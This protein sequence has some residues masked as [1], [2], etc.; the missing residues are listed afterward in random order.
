MPG[1]QT[2]FEKAMSDGHSSA[3]DQQW[4][5]AAGFYRAALQE[6]P[7][8]HSAL[9]N[10]G[11]ALF[12]Q[13]NF[14]EAL[15]IYQRAAILSPEDPVPPEKMARIYERLGRLNEA[16]RA[17]MQA[18]ELYLKTRDVEKSIEDWIRVTVLQPENLTAYTRLAMIY[19]RLGRKPEAVA[20]YLNAASLFQHAG[21]GTKALQIIQYAQNLLPGSA[22]AQQYLQAL[23][24]GNPLPRPVRPRGGTGPVRMAEVRQL[25]AAADAD[26]APQLDPISEA[27]QRALVELAGL[28]FDQSEDVLSSA[29]AEASGRR[30]INA[31]ARGTGELTLDSRQQTKV[32]LHLGQAI[33][34][35]THGE[36][37]RAGDELIRAVEVGFSHPALHF[38]IGYL[39]AE[40]DAAKA[41]RSLHKAV[42]APDYA[43]AANLLLGK[44]AYQAK[45]YHDAAGYDLQAMRLADLETVPA[46]KRDELYQLYEPA[47]ESQANEKDEGRLKAFCESIASQLIRADWRE[48]LRRARAQLPEQSPEAPPMPLSEMLVESRSAGVIE[49]LTRI[50]SL[51]GRGMLQTAMEE[52]FYTLE[53]APTY[54]PLHTAI[55]DLLLQDGKVTDAV[56][57]YMLVVR[58][59][60]LRGDNT[61]A[62]SLLKH[63]TQVA[64]MD[65]SVHNRLIEL[66]LE[67]G[68]IDDAIQQTMEKATV[69]YRL[70]ELDATR[71]TYLTA[72]RLVQ[73]SAN[74]RKWA[75]Q[76]LGRLADLDVQRLDWRQAL[77]FYEQMRTLQPEDQTTRQ[78]LMDLN[79]RLGQDKAAYSELENYLSFLQDHH[80]LAQAVEFLRSMIT[81]LPGKHELYRQ[82]ANVFIRLKRTEEA[83]QILDRLA[84]LYMDQDD[85]AQALSLLEEIIR[86]NPLN[87]GQYLAALEQLRGNG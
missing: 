19:E 32:L 87:K 23:K 17:G 68:R 84:D 14:D 40:R 51:A 67:Q 80:Q 21:D 20:A 59:Y 37:A 47:A 44:I 10:L 66:L 79:F 64:P 72:L 7:E 52:A 22:E 42:K 46:E 27:R 60:S 54:L 83:V 50:R 33:E 69:Y 85:R 28:L 63:L 13:Q 41:I 76:V 38:D 82:L 5:R 45:N 73:R 70:G 55:G 8:N 9:T 56:A 16:V 74:N 11:L 30:G 24:A 25:E 48:F 2:L 12:E 81:D 77:R 1:N 62:I 3:W 61:Q 75:F 65:L 29:A 31:L 26:A 78:H 57:K 6:F 43:L 39:F 15:T 58:L 34:Y 36:E 4:E 71:Q 53:M 35:Q 49:G 86:L 18:A